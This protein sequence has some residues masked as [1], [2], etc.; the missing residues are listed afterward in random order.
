M[1]PG[2]ERALGTRLGA[3]ELPRQAQRSARDQLDSD[4]ARPF[5]Y[6]SWRPRSKVT[7]IC[8][9]VPPPP[10]PVLARTRTVTGRKMM[11]RVADPDEDDLDR[12]IF[13]SNVCVGGGGWDGRLG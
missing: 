13:N 3:A 1:A 12:S 9:P 7:E 10:F 8:L 4:R 2:L 6:P 11:V 5:R